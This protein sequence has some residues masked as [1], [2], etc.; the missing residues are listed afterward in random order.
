MFTD[1]THMKILGLNLNDFPGGA[2]GYAYGVSNENYAYV[3]FGSNGEG[4]F[5]DLWR[6]NFI[7][8]SWLQLASMP[9]IGRNHPAMIL[10]DQKIFV[11]LGSVDSN[12]LGDWWEYDTEG[13]SGVKNQ[14][15]LFGNRH[16]PFYFSINNIPYVGFGHGNYV[17]DN[18]V[19]Y[20]DFYK[21]DS[22][23]NSWIQLSRFSL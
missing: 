18:I 13:N 23:N 7:D 16:H 4:Y 17:N 3:G 9:D 22:P 5:N 6:F 8:N 21:F 11:G 2:R 15:L 1:L 20:N 14:I 12:N 10:T 19:I